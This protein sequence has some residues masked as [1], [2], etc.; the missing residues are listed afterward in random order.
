[1]VRRTDDGTRAVQ[2]DG[3]IVQAGRNVV[4]G[5][6]LQCSVQHVEELAPLDV[7]VFHTM[8]TGR[9]RLRLRG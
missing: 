8:H 2:A 3:G 6:R 5:Y 4:E 1:M 7:C 9:G